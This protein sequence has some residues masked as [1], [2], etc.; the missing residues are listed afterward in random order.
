VE[1]APRDARISEKDRL[2]FLYSGT[3]A[4]L[5][6]PRLAQK[7]MGW[8]KHA[9]GK[10]VKWN[11]DL[12]AE[13]FEPQLQRLNL[14]QDQIRAQDA[15]QL[16]DSINRINEAKKN[17]A[18][19]GV[20]HIK[21]TATG[22][23]VITTPDDGQTQS[24]IYPVLLEREKTIYDLLREKG[25]VFK[26]GSNRRSPFT[27]PAVIAAVA[28]AIIA[29]AFGIINVI[30][31]KRVDNDGQ[32][33][34]AYPRDAS[35]LTGGEYEQDFSVID[36]NV[37]IKKGAIFNIA[38]G[39]ELNITVQKLWIEGEAKF[40]GVGKKG[41]NGPPAAPRADDWTSCGSGGD[42]HQKWLDAVAS[43]NPVDWGNEGGTGKAGGPGANVTIVYCE[44]D[45]WIAENLSWKLDGGAG[46]EGGAGGKGRKLISCTT[47]EHKFAA[48][49]P[50]GDH[51]PAGP[52][53]RFTV[54]K[55]C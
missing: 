7:E 22:D 30:V 31:Q 23:A 27:H 54:R 9:Q 50:P 10:I 49:G 33:T 38:G 48:N 41:E 8:D 29:G 2:S 18:Q 35:V 16:K 43:N 21:F 51:G 19:F 28:A 13:Y 47:R 39:K 25:V 40:L 52:D 55:E 14:G 32:G 6:S 5:E 20:L 53:G 3:G 46:G 1:S 17:P 36:D 45:G 15:Q 24:S 26:D 11:L 44:L 42:T 4:T 34:F 37:V 12:I